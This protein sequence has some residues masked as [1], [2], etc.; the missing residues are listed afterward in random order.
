MII[1]TTLFICDG[2]NVV[3]ASTSER[4]PYTSKVLLP[5]RTPEGEWAAFDDVRLYCVQCLNSTKAKA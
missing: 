2:C 1:Q 5:P 4:L 3:V